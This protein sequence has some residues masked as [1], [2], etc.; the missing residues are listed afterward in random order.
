MP[1]NAFAE[2]LEPLLLD[3]NYLSEVSRQLAVGG[4]GRSFRVAALNRAVV[5]ACASA[6]E[7]YIEELVK[8]SLNVLRRRCRPLACGLP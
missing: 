2:F 4:S 6:W 3:A 1:S 8:E 7:A 5:V